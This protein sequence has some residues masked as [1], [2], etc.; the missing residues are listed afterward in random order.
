MLAGEVD[1]AVHSLKDVPTVLPDG[2]S[3]CAFLE[4][5]DPR[6]ALALGR[7][8]RSRELPAGATGGHDEPAAA[9]AAA[10]AAA[11]PRPRRPA[12]QRGH[13][14]PPAAR[15]ALRRD[16]PRDGGP[17]AARAGGRGDRG[18]RPAPLRARAR[19]RGR[20]PS[21]AGTGTR[22]CATPWRRSTTPRPR[23]R[24]RPSAPSWP[25][26]GGGCN[27]PLGAHAFAADGAACELVAFVAAAD[28][29][30]LLRGERRG[31]DA[32]GPRPRAGRGPA[33]PAG[34]PRPARALMARARSPAAASSSRGGRARPSRLADLLAERGATVLEVP[35]IEIVPPAR[36]GAAR[37]GARRARRY[38][39][40]VL[41]ERQRGRRGARRGIAVL[42][43]R[44][45]PAA[46][47]EPGSPRWDGPRPRRCAPR[48]RR[49]GWRSS[50]RT[51]F[52][53]EALARGLRGA[54]DC[55]GRAS[56]LP[57]LDARPRRA[58]RGACGRWGPRSTWSPPT[59][60][61]SRRA[62]PSAVGR[63]ASPRASTS[64]SSPRPRPSRL[65][66]ARPGSGRGASR[67]RS[68]GPTTEAAARAGGD[69]RAGGGRSPRRPRGSW[70]P[71]ERAPG[72][73]AASRS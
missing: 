24:W 36:L 53:A 50:R 61:S 10:G 34:R 13:A 46:G 57:V 25:A 21:S 60:P 14:D 8:A 69:G 70:P 35:A 20:S 62:S 68:S 31:A 17:H 71:A 28:G 51:D 7:D 4:R 44:A 5:A 33:A 23:A 29:R 16:P 63:A 15:G 45:A 55:G 32:R 18:P 22:R 11:R 43:A 48:S 58:R 27:V 19:G 73:R 52:R 41:H 40:V 65:S 56:S 66:P 6:D 72:E 49:T 2:L 67:P 30:G 9:G 47:A 54:H 37:R 12:R 38:D 26:L 3:L 1:L 39:W 42:G 64:P 59:R